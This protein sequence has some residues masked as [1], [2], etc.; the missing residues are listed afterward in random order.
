MTNRLKLKDHEHKLMRISRELHE[1][2]MAIE[3][4]GDNMA[5]GEL[6]KLERAAR[7][8][9]INP[10]LRARKDGERTPKEWVQFNQHLRY[11]AESASWTT[12]IILGVL[13]RGMEEGEGEEMKK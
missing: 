12:E 8:F 13:E 6:M 11:L 4:I 3:H 5:A 2:A 10:A 9:A 7:A 1:I